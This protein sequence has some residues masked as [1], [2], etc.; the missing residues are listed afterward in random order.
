[1]Q[2]LFTSTARLLRWLDIIE[3]IAKILLYIANAYKQADNNETTLP[4]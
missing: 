1:M 3:W 2:Q 4:Q